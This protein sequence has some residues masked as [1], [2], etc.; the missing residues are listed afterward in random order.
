MQA[1]NRFST[2]QLILSILAVSL[3]A[4]TA[5]FIIARNTSTVSSSSCEGTCV[6]LTKDGASPNSIA[7]VKGSTVQFNSADGKTHSLSLG[8]G[9]EE[10]SHTG[11]FSSGDFKADEGWRVQ[12]N[13]EGSFY[14]HDHFNPKINVLVVVYTPGKEYKVE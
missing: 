12:F 2:L 7:I 13:D 14:F 8:K 5:A 6:A 9:G 11:K 1:L 3:L 4:F 10:H